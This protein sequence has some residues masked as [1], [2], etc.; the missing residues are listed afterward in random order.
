MQSIARDELPHGGLT[1]LCTVMVPRRRPAMRKIIERQGYRPSHDL[2]IWGRWFPSRAA[3]N[4]QRDSGGIEQT[5]DNW[6]ET[7]VHTIP[8][9]QA[10]KETEIN[11]V[12]LQYVERLTRGLSTP[13]AVSSIGGLR[14]PAPPCAP[15][16]LHGAGIRKPTQELT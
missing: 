9:A 4:K 14:T 2:L 7:M 15:H 8:W 13:S 1:K 12:R 3:R 5:T 11:G 6:E 16:H 10:A